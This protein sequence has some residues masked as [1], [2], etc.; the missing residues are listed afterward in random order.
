MK[1]LILAQ[2]LIF[3]VC[4]VLAQ[5]PPATF[6]LRNVNGENYV[7]SVK[8]QQG[9][10]CWTF[11]AMAAMEGNLLMTGAWAASGE[12]GEPNLAE[13]H[14]DWWNGFNQ[15]NNDDI[16]PPS[17][18]GLEVHQGGDY[19]VTSA[20]ISRNEG[21]V[22][23]IDG[24][25]YNAP[26]A[27]WDAG[28]HY[29]YPRNIEWYT[30]DENLNG[31]NLI[32]QKIMEN[33]VMGTCMCYDGSFMSNY[34]HYQPPTST[35]DPNHAVAIIGWDD[36]MATQAPLPGAWLV[37]NSWGAGWGNAGFFWISYYDK[38][39]C[40]NPEMGA[41][42]F[43]DVEPLQYD[44]TYCHDYH[45]WRDTKTGTTEAFNAFVAESGDMLSSVSFF[46]AVHNVDFAVKIYDNFTSGVLQNELASVSGHIDYSGLH[47]IDLPEPVTLNQGD[48]FY[49]FLQLSD[50]GIPYDRTSDV[51][52]LLGASYRAI[53]ESTANP[54]ESFY[55]EDG[56]WKDFYDYN[57]PSGYEHTGNFCIKGL[58]KTAYGMKTG[59][60]EIL[61]PTGNNNGRID[62]GETV[63]IM[64]T[65][66]N[67]GL[68]NI[69]D[70]AA[71]FTSTDP[72]T[73]I[74]SG[75]LNFGTITPGEEATA[76]FSISADPATPVGHTIIG[77]L[78]VNCVSNGND[79]TYN[80]DLGFVVGLVVEDFETGD[81][82]QY[83]WESYGDNI[84][85][86]A[87]SG[88]Y[89][90]MYC[91]KSGTIGHNSESYL[92]L[93]LNVIA[94]GEISFYRK[95]SSEPDYDYLQFY[96]D[97]QMR[98]EWSGEQDWA[99]FTYSVTAGEHTFMWLYLKDVSAIGG[100]DCAWLDYIIFP[101]IEGPMPPLVHQQIAIPQGWSGISGYLVPLDGSLEKI[102]EG[103]A[104]N[105]VI[106]QDMQGAYWP[107]GGMN[108]IG[109]W[110]TQSGYKIKVSEN[111]NLD[112]S[113]Y[114][115]VNHTLELNEG[116]NLIPVIS[117]SIVS[118]EALFGSLG[119]DL[120][121]AKEVAGSHVYWPGEGV[122][123]LE[124]LNSGKS[125]L[126]KLEAPGSVTF[127]Q[128]LAFNATPSSEQVKSSNLY[129]FTPSGNSHVVIF[130]SSSL[131]SEVLV[132]DEIFAL[133]EG[134]ICSGSVVI[135]DLTQTI[136]LVVF[137][138]DST[139]SVITG[140]SNNEPMNFIL[141]RPS[142]NDAFMLAIQAFDPT[143]PNQGSYENEGLSKIQ[144]FYIQWEG[145]NEATVP[146][147]YFSPNP[148]N[149][150]ITISGIE[151]WPVNIEIVNVKG[152]HVI[153][154]IKT[155]EKEVN[156]SGLHNG[157]YFIRITNDKWNVVRKLVV[158]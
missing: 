145:I 1:K 83:D 155:S 65:L 148:T 125:Y 52:V 12:T 62:P 7:T 16:N 146:T 61:D 24:Q 31:I 58:A 114:D 137:G 133:T 102:F 88:A 87:N 63:Q 8:N 79:F 3:A 34:I 69:T 156:L 109:N 30:M 27:R 140:F 51:P 89:E 152:Q 117:S 103:I 2:F 28:Y 42:S 129:D 142:M 147:V 18:S 45:G 106:V 85:A 135:S 5:T 56:I 82:S 121:I 71:K 13:Y 136:A 15:N 26:P 6:D 116:W 105:L 153:S 154:L 64:V 92:Q 108:T 118:C 33:G 32:K 127:P 101:P 21:A 115:L 9:G 99:H 4:T 130:P 55:H 93:S 151:S 91:A 22:R 36:A 60:I 29:Y 138:N 41:I 96:V 134:G 19:R 112:F 119:G 144:T 113:G 97:S 84:W 80:F 39:A 37:K 25:S 122:E 149:D 100:S 94:D 46:T 10:T 77:S 107:A 111:V 20:Y 139:S 132:G 76:G 47:T 59:S 150:K 53:V 48:D 75:I 11:G 110:N 86:V 124:N 95:V 70:I 38:H 23:D 158:K 17:G 50:G 43:Q 68:F 35:L 98:D 126:V 104:N 74:N 14:L 73:L 72:Y 143:F 90:G 78:D 128:S 67:T 57:D 120:I 131:V 40:R 81:F 141:Y 54:G 123:T 66:K 44:K 49:I 157:F